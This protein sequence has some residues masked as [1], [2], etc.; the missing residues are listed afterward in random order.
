MNSTIVSRFFLSVG[1]D[2]KVTLTAMAID[3]AR[4]ARIRTRLLAAAVLVVPA[5][6]NARQTINEPRR[7]PAPTQHDGAINE[8][9]VDPPH[10]TPNPDPT[11]KPNE[12][13]HINTPPPQAHL[14]EGPDG[15]DINRPNPDTTTRVISPKNVP[16]T[17]QTTNKAPTAAPIDQHVNTP[18]PAPKKKPKENVNTPEPMP[19]PDHINT[20]KPD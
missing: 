12:D 2:L 16:P 3:P 17:G 14:G 20:P 11:A 1:S 13:I 10:A 19:S 8:V 4:L 18:A 7:E 6:G 15:R 9:V 5:C